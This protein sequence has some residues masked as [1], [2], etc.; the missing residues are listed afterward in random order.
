MDLDEYV[1]YEK[2]NNENF[3]IVDFAKKVGISLN[4]MSRLINKRLP[5]SARVAYLIDSVTEG[6]VSGWDLIKKRM[7]KEKNG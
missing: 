1:F 3:R 5:P 6:K 4:L 7:E 2:K